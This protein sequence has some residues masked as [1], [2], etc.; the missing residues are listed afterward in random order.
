MRKKSS[1]S[2]VA[3][4]LLS[5]S[6]LFVMAPL[7]SAAPDTCTWTGDSTVSDNFSESSGGVTN[8]DCSS[9]GDNVLPENNDLIAFDNTGASAPIIA[10]NDMAGLTVDNISFTGA[11]SQPFTVSGASAIT[12]SGGTITNS[13]SATATVSVPL[14]I[15]ASTDFVAG[16]EDLIIS[17]S[18]SGTFDI[19]KLGTGTLVLSGVN[20]SYSGLLTINAGDVSVEGADA[21]GTAAGAGDATIVASGATLVIDFYESAE[22]TLAEQ[23]NLSGGG[24]TN[25][26]TLEVASENGSM[27]LSGA[28]ILGTA[29]VEIG[30]S[31]PVTLSGVLSGAGGLSYIDNSSN[32]TASLKLTGANTY[33]G[34]TTVNDTLIITGTQTNSGITVASGGTLKGTGTANTVIINTGGHLAPGLSP[35]CLNAG[36][37]TISG[38]FDVELGGTTA[39]TEYDQLQV[40]GAVD[41]T[42][43]TLNL[44]RYNGFTPATGQSFT[45]IAN[46]SND[47]VT[48]TFTGVAEGGTVTVDGYTFTVSYVGGDGN[49]V[50][51]TVTGVPATAPATPSAPNTGMR[52]L[53]ANPALTFMLSTL[54]AAVMTLLSR[55]YGFAAI[56]K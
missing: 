18:I 25:R 1:F 9:D 52:L 28:I 22:S 31:R 53:L 14:V 26:Q 48:G 33:A 16:S 56:R 34:D 32:N 30:G 11:T 38:N 36:A 4:F 2:L 39:C 3:S 7:V 12:L 15:A 45:I 40:T 47:A 17:G 35:G 51:V 46:D 43:G 42:S 49:D 8:W 10:V 50:V 37:T 19:T 5:V 27:T 13:S 21:L 55:R 41:V 29:D 54:A 20:T 6:S 24:L 44:S 23:I